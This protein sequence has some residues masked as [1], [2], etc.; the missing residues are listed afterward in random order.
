SA[1][2]YQLSTHV[3]DITSGQPA[4][5]VKVELYK[6]EANQQWK[7]VSEEFTE[8]NGR[9]GDLLP[10]EKAENRAFGIYKLKFFTKDYY[11]SHKINTFYPFV[12]VSF[13][14]SKDQKHYHVP[15]T[16]SPFG[17]STYRGS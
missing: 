13:E 9:I 2:E 8:E 6:L 7:K 1:T 10:Y 3:L 16:L 4:P 14:L 17:Y 5:K 15:I 11:T 12:E